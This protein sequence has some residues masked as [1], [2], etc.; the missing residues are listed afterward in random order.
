MLRALLSALVV[1]LP[2][3]PAG[4]KLPPVVFQGIDSNVTEKSKLFFTIIIVLLI[5]VVTKNFG[6]EHV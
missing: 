1:V 3:G 6:I 5:F 2:S 4:L